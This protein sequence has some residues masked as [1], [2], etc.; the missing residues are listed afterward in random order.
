M[1]HAMEAKGETNCARKLKS[2]RRLLPV[3]GKVRWPKPGKK[4][5]A[6]TCRQTLIAVRV[7]HPAG[8]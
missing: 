1:D 6:S 5:R 4:L 3:A 8:F 7:D 2:G